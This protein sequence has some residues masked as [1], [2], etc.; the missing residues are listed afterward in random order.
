MALQA[1][2]GG[3]FIHSGSDRAARGRFLLR[4]AQR[5]DSAMLKDAIDVAI[6][7]KADMACC[8]AYVCF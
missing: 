5:N 2:P 6:G 4:R 7:G 3:L 1:V 8:S